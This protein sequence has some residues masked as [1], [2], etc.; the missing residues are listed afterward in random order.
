MK[1]GVLIFSYAGMEWFAQSLDQDGHISINLGDYMQ[2]LAAR[3]LFDNLGVDRS[4]VIAVDRDTLP[5][6][7]GEP[8]ALIMNGCFFHHCFPVPDSIIPIFVGFQASEA[9]IV[10]A[11]DY[12]R[13]HQP[14]GCRDPTTERIF[15]K[16]GIAA[17]TTGCLT[18]TLPM[19]DDSIRG[20]KV[21][22]AYGT[23]AGDFPAEVMRLMPEDL[24]ERVELVYQRKIVH[25]FPMRLN[26]MAEAEAYALY[27]LNYYR[28]NA[29]LIVTPL[30]HAASP[31]MASGIPVNIVRKKDNSRF[32]H[33]R[34]LVPVLVAPNFA[35]LVWADTPV[36]LSRVR[37]N[38]SNQVGAALSK[39]HAF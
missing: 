12:F 1:V 6:Y 38:L 22:V 32:G 37:Q 26:D 35:D 14:I 23:G 5:S 18:L 21:I 7:D 8:V 16:H 36:D 20:S 24:L 3:N 4:N 19:R 17:F 33:L 13:K 39:A 28:E 25:H 29:S 30:H 11:L 9:V 15:R 10:G 27:L 34:T 2:T 31:G